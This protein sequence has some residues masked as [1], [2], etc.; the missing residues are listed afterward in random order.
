[1]SG[2]DHLSSKSFCAPHENHSQGMSIYSNYK[3]KRLDSNVSEGFIHIPCLHISEGTSNVPTYKRL[4]RQ[5]KV[6]GFNTTQVKARQISRFF[7]SIK[8]SSKKWIKMMAKVLNEEG[9]HIYVSF[10]LPIGFIF[11]P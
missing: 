10:P 5:Q 1:M 8:K 11:T 9:S 3:Y 7:K 6:P 2:F 4:G